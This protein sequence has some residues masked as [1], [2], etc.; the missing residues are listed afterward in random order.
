VAPGTGPGGE[1]AV[2]GKV[3]ITWPIKV[4]RLDSREILDTLIILY[5]QTD[6]SFTQK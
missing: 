5:N 3:S 6:L 1:L 2:A 4:K